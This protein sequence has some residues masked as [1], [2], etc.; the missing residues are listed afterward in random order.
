MRL[1]KPFKGK[2]TFRTAAGTVSGSVVDGMIVIEAD[3]R[4]ARHLIRTH[5]F[6]HSA[7]KMDNKP[8]KVAK[9]AAPKKKTA[10]KK[11]T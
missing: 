5:G 9:K 2:S 6:K 4:I 3:P 10:P 7:I 1:A 8:K 11:S